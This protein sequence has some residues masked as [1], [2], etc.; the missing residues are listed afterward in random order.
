MSP[1]P[2]CP[3][4]VRLSTSS[5]LR[6]WIACRIL[7][8]SSRT[9]SAWNEIGGS[10]AVRLMSCMMWLGTMSRKRAGLIVV[11]AALLHADRFRHRDLH[12][13]DV[14]AV[15]DRLEDSVGK[16]E[17]QNVLHR[18]FAQ[19]VVDAVNLLFVGDLQQLLVQRFGRLQV[20]PKGFSM[21][22]RRQLLLLL[23]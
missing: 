22:T 9:A 2:Y 4:T 5:E 20:V 21:I 15:P 11:A 12:V 8:C 13:I 3:R 19:V 14:A 17:R 23:P 16:T 7:A 10:I 18:L 1:S 6:G